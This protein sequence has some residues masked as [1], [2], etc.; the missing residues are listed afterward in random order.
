M[1]DEREL[2]KGTAWYYAKYRL[3][4]PQS[5][6]DHLVTSFNLDKASRVL[7]LGTGT[8][9]IAIPMAAL[10]K[11]VVA[12]DPEK[13]MLEEGKNQSEQK[14]VTNITW[15]QSKAED[16]SSE[17]GIFKA[18]TIGAAF[19]WMEQDKVL[20]KVYELT[21]SGGGVAIVANVSTVINNKGG[22]AWKD[23]A[24]NTIREFLGEERRAGNSTYQAPKDRFEIIL[25]RSKFSRC[26]TFNDTYQVPRSVEDIIGYLGSTSF[27]SYR[28]FGDR[29]EE[30]KKTLT[31]RLLK[32]EP[33]GRFME[34][35]VVEAYLGWK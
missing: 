26:Q 22:D 27:A 18:T 12:V 24:W 11:E 6:F 1:S 23:V 34:T 19:H 29:L 4:Y 5:F 2:F 35:A 13:E 17:L 10:V 28:L 21:E 31:E 3:G 25:A 30:F 7:D 15:L 20:E 33:S 9:Q 16:I 32:L 8:G 14:Q